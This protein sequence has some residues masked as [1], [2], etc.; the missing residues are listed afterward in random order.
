LGE[1]SNIVYSFVL[2][3]KWKLRMFRFRICMIPPWHPWAFCAIQDD[4]QDGRQFTP[5]LFNIE[6]WFWCQT[7]FLGSRNSLK[8]IIK[9][10]MAV[11]LKEKQQNSIIIHPIAI[12]VESNAMFSGSRNFLKWLYDVERLN[13]TRIQN[14]WHFKELPYVPTQSSDFWIK[15]YVFGAISTI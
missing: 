8:V 9:S 4:V 5:P 15:T 11:V 13:D 1:P 6:I 3:I 7:L 10:K 12:I 2:G 14:I